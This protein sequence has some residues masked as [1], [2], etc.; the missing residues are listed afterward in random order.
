MF[1]DRNAYIR[2]IIVG[3][4]EIVI[5]FHRIPSHANEKS[6]TILD[7]DLR[8]TN[9]YASLRDRYEEDHLFSLAPVPDNFPHFRVHGRGNYYGASSC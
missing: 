6:L 7:C 5:F 8:P 2:K 4:E 9:G 3:G 1:D